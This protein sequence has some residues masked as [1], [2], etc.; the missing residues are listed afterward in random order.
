MKVDIAVQSYNKPESL[1]Y[2]LFKLHTV[3]RDRVSTVWINDD[4]SSIEV[5]EK[6]KELIRS[7]RLSPWK[8]KLRV[9]RSRMGWWLAFVRGRRPVY[10]TTLF[11]LKRMLWNLM[12]NKNIF[13][14]EDDIRYQWAFNQT[15]RKYLFVMHDDIFF[16][17]DIIS[18]Y[19]NEYERLESDLNRRAFIVGDLGQ[20]WR[21]PHSESGCTPR[22]VVNGYRPSNEWPL[23]K[24][25]GEKHK[26]PC[27]I[28]EWSALVDVSLAREILEHEHVYFGNYDDDGDVAAYWFSRG[29]IRGFHFSD[30]LPG[31]EERDEYYLHWEDGVTGH[32]AWVDQGSGVNS[33]NGDMFALRLKQEFDYEI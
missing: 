27:R 32:S 8:V 17:R 30:P 18:L 19:L 12:K 2:S 15:E 14:A 3:S 29:V 25:V 23:S 22:K 4:Q 33:Y 1:I 26:W 21:C 10:Q 16:E 20:C 11:R 7:N 28:N 9:N 6:Y 5:I 24:R 31:K 13:V